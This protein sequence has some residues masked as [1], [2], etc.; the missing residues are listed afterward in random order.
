MD[1]TRR[2]QKRKDILLVLLLTG[3]FFGGNA[4]LR[5]ATDTYRNFYDLPEAALWMLTQNGRA[6]TA[7]L[8][9]IFAVFRLPN[10]ALFHC[11]YY[12]GL[13]CFAAAFYLLWQLLMSRLSKPAALMVTAMLLC[14]PSMIDF[15][16]FLETGGFLIGVLAMVLAVSC[17]VQYWQSSQ[18]RQ[19]LWSFLCLLTAQLCYQS[20]PTGFVVLCLPF[21]L[22]Y[23]ADKPLEFVKQNL[24]VASLYASVNLLQLVFLNLVS[25][26]TRAPSS[27]MP[28]LRFLLHDVI[29]SWYGMFGSLIVPD[30]GNIYLKT[31]LHILITGLLVLL[32]VIVCVVQFLSDRKTGLLLRRLFSICYILCGTFFTQAVLFSVSYPALR[33]ALPLSLVNGVLVLNLFL[34]LQMGQA[35]PIFRYLCL[36]VALLQCFA[37]YNGIR[38][39]FTEQYQL[40]AIDKAQCRQIAAKIDAYEQTT[41]RKIT[42]IATY[43]GEQFT[44]FH[45]GHF[46]SLQND[47][48][49]RALAQPWCDVDAISY[50][51]N[52]HFLRGE[53]S[54]I[55]AAQFEGKTADC[56]HEDQLIFDGDTLHLLIY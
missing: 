44:Y 47:V 42:K 51:A 39:G 34:N 8:Y 33:L 13:L 43:R 48:F 30:F 32:S 24:L 1:K 41:G 21:L 50:Y 38:T 19:L 35:K 11:S 18:K 25:H 15:F 5:F 45:P 2:S 49:V 54:S 4:S 16:L 7:L 31:R 6:V 28:P 52:R 23:K 36:T 26:S 29:T 9:G 55:A 3:L 46:T 53:P 40:N 20:I 12:L 17:M 14:N 37:V 22:C 10:E 56:F 27:A